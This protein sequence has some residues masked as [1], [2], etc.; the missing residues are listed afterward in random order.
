MT[1]EQ[2]KIVNAI[3]ELRSMAKAG[4]K[5]GYSVSSVSRNLAALE[6]E[7]GIKLFN[8]KGKTS[9]TLTSECRSLISYF[10][11]AQ[12]A[13]DSIYSNADKQRNASSISMSLAV[14][15][16]PLFEL[17]LLNCF[18]SKMPGC[19]I[20]QYKVSDRE[21]ALNMKNGQADAGFCTVFG[22]PRDCFPELIEAE[23]SGLSCKVIRQNSGVVYVNK[24][25]PLAKKEYVSF[26]D[27]K[28]YP[29]LTFLFTER[30]PIPG[31]YRMKD[32]CIKNGI[33]V[34]IKQLVSQTHSDVYILNQLVFDNPNYL[35]YSQGF[36]HRELRNVKVNFRDSDD[37]MYSTYLITD[38]NNRRRELKAL[39]SSL[40][41]TLDF[42]I[43]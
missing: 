27:I 20:I 18:I 37:L 38:P 12:K 11:D 43:I 25:H 7:L 23:K 35:Y 26:A 42:K 30:D 16:S 41:D 21:C 28:N 6:E 33:N 40:D 36:A 9:I 10:E 34:E 22:S 1:Y 8:R 39:I 13:M 29:E 31:L 5:T 17:D 14:S 32:A 3:A 2:I 24:L 15:I 4:E 19:N